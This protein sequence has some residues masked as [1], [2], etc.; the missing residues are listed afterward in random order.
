MFNSRADFLHFLQIFTAAQ[1][2]LTF[3]VRLIRQSDQREA[4]W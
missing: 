1:R 3:K 2:S 4:Q